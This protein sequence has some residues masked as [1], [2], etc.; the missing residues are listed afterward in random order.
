MR[1][2]STSPRVKYKT[3]SER[4]EHI[5][6]QLGVRLLLPMPTACGSGSA[7]LASFVFGQFNFHFMCAHNKTIADTLAKGAFT[8][9]HWQSLVRLFDMHPPPKPGVNRDKSEPFC[10]AVPSL[11]SRAMSD[12]YSSQ[13]HFESGPWDEKPKNPHMELQINAPHGE[14]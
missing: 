5:I 1:S 4:F 2:H 6:L 9:I 7:Q 3:V 8:T 11:R 10:L 13:R 12:A 14:N